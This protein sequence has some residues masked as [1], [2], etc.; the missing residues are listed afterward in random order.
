VSAAD[1]APAD[2]GGIR[3]IALRADIVQIA[4]LRGGE[5]ELGDIATAQGWS[6]PALGRSARA[7]AP[8]APGLALSVRPGRW[9]LL[10]APGSPG[11]AAALWQSACAGCGAAVDL[12]SALAVMRLEGAAVR[13][14]LARGCRL[15][16]AAEVFPSGCAAATIMAQV[17]VVLAALGAGLMLLTPST[18]ADHLR[19]WLSL[20]AAPFGLGPRSDA[21]VALLSGDPLK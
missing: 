16:L 21:T 9:L 1:R 12:S 2:A 18:T 4:Q 20:T 6:L 17:P 8:A 7:A 3:L 13:E 11:G 5:R 19:E 14:M 10:S 15:D